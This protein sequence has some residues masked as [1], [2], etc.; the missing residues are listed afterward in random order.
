MKRF[1]ISGVMECGKPEMIWKL[2][3]SV[4]NIAGKPCFAIQHFRST[5]DHIVDMTVRLY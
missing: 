4:N 3:F 5:I 1:L 2:L